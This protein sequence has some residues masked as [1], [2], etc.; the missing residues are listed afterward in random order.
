MNRCDGWWRWLGTGSP[1]EL[2]KPLHSE[3]I[4]C[5]QLSGQEDLNKPSSG[6]EQMRGGRQGGGD[7]ERNPETLRWR[8]L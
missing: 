8:L 5:D 1:G 3:N 6:E 4:D 2:E 7:R